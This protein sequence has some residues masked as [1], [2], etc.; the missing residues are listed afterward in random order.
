VILTSE[1]Q[2]ATGGRRTQKVTLQFG[3][4]RRRPGGPGYYCVF[5]YKGF[6]SDD[7]T[8]CLLGIDGIQVLQFAIQIALVGLYSST[9]YREGR[10]TWEGSKDLAVGF[11][12]PDAI[13][14]DVYSEPTPQR[15]KLPRKRRS[16]RLDANEARFLQPRE[17][18]AHERL[19]RVGIGL[20]VE[21][22]LGGERQLER[23]VFGSN[24]HVSA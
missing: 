6:G 16:R 7:R 22:V 14:D 1:Y 13:K 12:L 15:S 21:F 5:R 24:V 19:L 18:A 9:A 17:N 23:R 8:R 4:P 20:A 3:K 2:L 11:P 10:L